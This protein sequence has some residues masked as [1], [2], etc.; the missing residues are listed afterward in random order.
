MLSQNDAQN[1]GLDAVMKPP[2]FTDL[3]KWRVPYVQASATDIARTFERVRADME[4]KQERAAKLR[5]IT[6]LT[7]RK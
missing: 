7:R 6:V 5:S 2:R 4:H 3:H 1:R